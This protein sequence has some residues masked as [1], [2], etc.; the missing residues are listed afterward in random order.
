MGDSAPHTQGVSR[1]TQIDTQEIV[2]L[3]VEEELSVREIA[4]R[5][6]RSY[7][8]IYGILRK[9]VLM[10]PNGRGPARST[11]YLKV[12]EVMR[13]R[14]GMGDWPPNRKILS[15][16]DLALIFGVGVQTVRDAT[17]HL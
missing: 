3:Y 1:M 15:Q 2:R 13:E 11:E 10:R 17:T 14:I 12:A 6:G 8:K 4:T 5:Y 9:R 16:Q 7:G